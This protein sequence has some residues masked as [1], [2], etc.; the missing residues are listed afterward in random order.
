MKIN[1][2]LKRISKSV[3]THVGKSGQIAPPTL[4]SA[5][6]FPYG[7]FQFKTRVEQ[8]A[9]YNILASTDLQNWVSISTD[10]AT[11][12][13]LD[14]VDSEASKFSY[15]FYR[16]VAGEAHSTNVI[17]YVSVTLP[18]GFSMIANPLIARHNTV[19]ELF[20]EFPDGTTLN[21]YDTRLFALNE[22][23]VKAKKWTNPGEKLAP[24]EGALIFNPTSDYRTHNFVGNVM[25]GNLLNPI[26]P[27]FSIR[28]SLLPKPG[29]LHLDLGF[30]IAEGDTIHLFDRD[31]QKYLI[32]PYD[33][34]KWAS[35]PPVIGVGE[36]FWVA[37]TSP[38][39][40]TQSLVVS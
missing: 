27:G 32:C 5:K 23:E 28:S 7:P 13:T 38:G 33:A 6:R 25:Q 16:L 9:Q 21:K 14:Y 31:K 11:G 24:G 1:S 36:S 22:N 10:I 39:N 8:G 35:N 19:D 3:R 12:E 20:P 30:P 40:W 34:A 29:R 15:R 4:G 17:G 18:P 26:P 2:L 37:K